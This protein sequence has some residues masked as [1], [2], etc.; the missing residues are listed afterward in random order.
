MDLFQIVVIFLTVLFL[1]IHIID[2][3]KTSQDLEVLETDYENNT[4]LQDVCRLKQPFVFLLENQCPDFFKHVNIET[5]LQY[6]HVDVTIKDTNDYYNSDTDATTVDY[7]ILPFQSANNLMKTDTRSH[8]FSENNQSFIG[9]IG[10]GKE[11]AKLDTFLKPYYSVQTTYDIMFGS[12]RATTP[13]IYHTNERKFLLVVS[14]KLKMKLTP[15]TS[16]DY[17]HTVRDFENYEFYSRM[18]VWKP[19]P[20]MI[21]EYEKI[22]FIEFEINA[23]DVIYIPP[24]W[25][26]TCQFDDEETC[27]SSATYN[28]GFN[29]LSNIPDMTLYYLQQWNITKKNGRVLP[30]KNEDKENTETKETQSGIVVEPTQSSTEKETIVSRVV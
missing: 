27:I 3:Y 13:L 17:L 10:F 8:F 21:R 16:K 5:M 2:Q 18:N 7:L 1:Y 4:Q 15:F 14:G 25:F 24:Y 26:Y 12:S 30:Q 9:E 20:S 29:I 11:F 22:R 6:P 19:N 23:G 28:T